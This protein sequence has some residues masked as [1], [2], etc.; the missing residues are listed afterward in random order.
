MLR[1]KCL[2]FGSFQSLWRVSRFVDIVDISCCLSCFISY[3]CKQLDK[4]TV[5]VRGSSLRNSGLKYTSK[6]RR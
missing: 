1:M 3:I 5:S 4:Y 2:S 6:K